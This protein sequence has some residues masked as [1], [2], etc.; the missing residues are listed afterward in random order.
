MPLAT[1]VDYG[2]THAGS[3]NSSG[4]RLISEIRFL[5]IFHCPLL[6]FV[7]ILLIFLYVSL[8]QGTKLLIFMCNAPPSLRSL[9][10]DLGATM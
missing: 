2:G 9:L 1:L 6:H 3:A 4:V 7:F 5:V 10:L 8:S